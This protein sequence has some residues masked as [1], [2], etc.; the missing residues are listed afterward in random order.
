MNHCIWMFSLDP[1]D[2]DPVISACYANEKEI[3]V[4]KLISSRPCLC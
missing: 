2:I 3:K 1:D 4:L